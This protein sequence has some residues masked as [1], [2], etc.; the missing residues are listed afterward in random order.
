MRG[1]Y[2]S[3]ELLA[4]ENPYPSRLRSAITER[5]TAGDLLGFMDHGAPGRNGLQFDRC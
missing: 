1:A 3:Q 5:L 4:L 2:R